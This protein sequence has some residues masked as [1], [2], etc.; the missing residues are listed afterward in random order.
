[1]HAYVLST[2]GLFPVENA[3]SGGKTPK[4][5]GKTPEYLE[6]PRETRHS[7]GNFMLMAEFFHTFRPGFR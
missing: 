1:M 2:F 5:E 6:N 3:R 7:I 4:S